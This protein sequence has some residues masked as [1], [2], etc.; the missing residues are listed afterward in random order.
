MGISGLTTSRLIRSPLRGGV[1]ISWT[2]ASLGAALK[3]WFKADT[4]I[5]LNSTTVSA[6]AD[7]SGNGANVSQGSAGN[8]PTFQGTGFNGLPTVLFVAASAT[9]LS[10]AASALAMGAA[11]ASV[12]IVGQMLT[13]TSDYGRAVS[14]QGGNAGADESTAG[15]G[16]LILRNSLSNA[17]GSYAS[18]GLRCSQAISLATNYRIGVIYDGSAATPYLNNVAGTPGGAFS[19]AFAAAGTL[20]LGTDPAGVFWGGAIS[21]VVIAN[22]ALSSG[23]RDSLDSYF[24]SKWG[25]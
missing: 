8:Q 20:R 12:F 9:S 5:T 23:D 2:P 10:S 17:F 4:G 21:E 19:T 1:P 14:F 18:S 25:L 3:A 16:A 13:G 11:A 24:R 15:S 22:A 6:W 7:Q